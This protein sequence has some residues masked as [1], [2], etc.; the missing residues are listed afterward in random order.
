[1]D[2]ARQSSSEF[3]TTADVAAREDF[4]LGSV[5][6]S[7]PTRTLRGPGGSTDVE[8][9]IMQVLLVLADAAGQVVT[10]DTL[11]ARCWGGVFVGDDSLNRAV[12]A[13]RRAVEAVGGTFEV[14]TIPRT[15]YRLVGA[16]VSRASS[17]H[18]PPRSLSRRQV[19]GGAIGVAALCG[20][21]GWSIVGRR[22]RFEV[23]IASAEDK[24]RKGTSDDSR[25]SQATAGS[26]LHSP[27]QRQGLGLA[28]I[29][30]KHWDGICESK[31][32]RNLRSRKRNTPR[33][34]RSRSTPGTRT[35]FWRCS[36]FR[37]R[38]SIGRRETRGSG[39]S[40][41]STP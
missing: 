33:P 8:P 26:D 19:A 36:S 27:G 23:L 14:E 24:V 41:R 13:L 4:A 16:T 35:R 2:V 37:A 21:A 5:T 32:S 9:R 39:R 31:K 38:H 34:K 6:V 18:G 11:F 40:L 17:V 1:M 29:P 30:R 22:R 7:P 12:A 25:S 20:I 15:G 10:R 3:L 28:R